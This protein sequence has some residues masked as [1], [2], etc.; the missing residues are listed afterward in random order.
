MTVFA[1]A[2]EAHDA[3]LR[4]VY[5]D[6]ATIITSTSTPG[7]AALVAK[8]IRQVGADRVLYGSDLSPPG[9]GIR[10]GWEVF[11]S[12]VP[13]T[14]AEHGTIMTNRPPFAR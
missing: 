12:K 4:R 2:A 6:V 7:D 8:R 11:R 1:V 9:G 14:Q 10:R 13:L 5:F 3:R